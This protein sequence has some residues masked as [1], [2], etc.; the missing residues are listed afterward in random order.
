M[1][2]A[3]LVWRPRFLSQSRRVDG[4]SVRTAILG[5]SNRPFPRRR[6]RSNGSARE[7]PGPDLAGRREAALEPHRLHPPARRSGS[8]AATQTPRGWLRAR[9]PGLPD[10]GDR[11]APREPSRL[12]RHRI[13][14]SPVSYAGRGPFRPPVG[15]ATESNPFG[16]PAGR[17]PINSPTRSV[18]LK[19]G[20]VPRSSASSLGS[21]HSK[22]VRDRSPRLSP[23]SGRDAG[24]RIHHRRS[25][26]PPHPRPSWRLGSP[27]YPGPR[28]ASRSRRGSRFTLIP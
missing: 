10:S 18:M 7:S 27:R 23:L 6:P 9:V 15:A 2:I 24:G 21:A 26:H 5:S 17:S 11:T 1:E 14:T 12:N 13:G 16:F 25:R 4:H 22:G 19:T 3:A 20:A 28:S 8:L